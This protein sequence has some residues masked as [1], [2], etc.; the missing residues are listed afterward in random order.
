MFK[1]KLNKSLNEMALGTYKTIGDFDK[2]GPFSAIDKK[3]VTH[4]GYLRKLDRFFSKTP[5][6]F[7]IWM[8]NVPGLQNKFGETGK[9]SEMALREIFPKKYNESINQIFAESESAMTIIFLGNYGAEK[10]MM[11]P[12]IVAHRIGHSLAATSRRRGGIDAWRSMSENFL[13]EI[14]MILDNYYGINKYENELASIFG[15]RPINREIYKNLF[16]AI[17]TQKSSRERT[18]NRPGEFLYKCFAQFILTGSVNFNPFPKTLS[19]TS[20]KVFGKDIDPRRTTLSDEERDELSQNMSTI[21]T[22]WFETIL[23]HN[24]GNVFLM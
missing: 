11:T 21:L 2:K 20:R 17:G 4:P 13:Y 18:L 16:Q 19:K 3:I 12:W 1:I 14:D 7:N 24:V 22:G 8:S 6:T 9:V 15:L 10:I 23:K 5:I